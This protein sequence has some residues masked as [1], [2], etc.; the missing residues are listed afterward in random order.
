MASVL[1]TTLT[2]EGKISYE[3]DIQ[4]VKSNFE[5]LPGKEISYGD[6]PDVESWSLPPIRKISQTGGTLV[7]QVAYNPLTK[8]LIRR[9][10]F[11]TTPSGEPGSI[12]DDTVQIE[13]NQSGRSDQE[14]ALLQAKK[15]HLD[16]TREGYG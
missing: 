6:K 14:Q 12:S 16:K 7:W 15:L 1:E 13:M 9:R 10:G 4:V 2:S 3:S 8:Q 5:P 11:E